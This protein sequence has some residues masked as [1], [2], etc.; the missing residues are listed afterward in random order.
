TVW[1][2]PAMLAIAPMQDFLGLGTEAR[3]NFPGTTSGWWRWRMNREDLS[4]ALA[5]QIQRLSE[6]YF[7]TDASD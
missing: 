6:I 3:M 7:R 4:P 5:R 1:A 2:S